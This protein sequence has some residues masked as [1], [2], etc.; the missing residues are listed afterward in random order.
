MESHDHEAAGMTT[1]R[2]PRVAAVSPSRQDDLVAGLSEVVGG[3]AG[4]RRRY[5]QPS[6]GAT[7]VWGAAPVLALL[8]MATMALTQLVAQPCRSRG[9]GPTQLVHMCYSDLPTGV[10][11][12]QE[13]PQSPGTWLITSTA[14]FLAPDA[15]DPVRTA[16]DLITVGLAVSLVMLVLAVVRL[17]GHRPWDA[18]MVALCP[19]VVTAG[20][21]STDLVALA[22]VFA[23]LA[24]MLPGR[25]DPSPSTGHIVGGGALIGLATT[26]RPLALVA[27]VAL[28][29]WCARAGRWRGFLLV[30]AG[31]VPAWALPNLLLLLHSARAWRAYQRSL[32]LPEPAYGS[33]MRIPQMLSQGVQPDQR[34]TPPL[35][36][37]LLGLA[38]LVLLL[39]VRSALPP[40]AR[41]EWL[42]L[43][44]RGLQVGAVLIVLLP[45]LAVFVAPVV[46][47]GLVGSPPGAVAARVVWVIGS[48]VVLVGVALLVALARRRPRLPVIML[49][50]TVGLLVVA[51]VVPVQAGLWLI[52][53]VALALPS[54]RVMVVF[55]TVECLYAMGTW[56][57]IYGL[58]VPARGLPVGWYVLV[59]AVRLV[60]WLA[61]AALAVRLTLRDE[62]DPVRNRPDP[63]LVLGAH[64][65][66]VRPGWWFRDDP[67]AGL[68]QQGT[69]D[70]RFS[71]TGR[72][73]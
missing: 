64:E 38:V 57:Y 30:L 12:S 61:L 31:A 54:W 52:P 69:S 63:D 32:F 49:L 42:P 15:G 62:L 7:F 28:A 37:G 55:A 68:L 21:I 36:V 66:R 39:A 59:L 16:V 70:R 23:G 35:W 45:L 1:T 60:T 58:S 44:D 19:V 17:A 71:P 13:P 4:R 67:A 26:V 40:A 33:V 22:L 6:F 2:A 8:S 46:L 41:Q 50:L 27:L 48:M 53:L 47:Q 73:Q 65:G 56:M 9:W 24:M 25:S 11:S 72:S 5:P 29:V 18:A 20:M 51:P 10:V 43:A 14:R 3:P 34:F